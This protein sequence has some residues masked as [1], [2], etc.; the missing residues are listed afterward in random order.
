[1]RKYLCAAMPLALAL[2][3]VSC[4]TDELNENVV[5]TPEQSALPIHN[6]NYTSDE[7]Q[8][9]DAINAHRQSIGQ[10]PLDIIN[11]VSVK[12]EEHNEYMIA[13][14]VVNHDNFNQRSQE[15]I[16]VLGAN[17][18]SENIAYNYS[19]GNGAVA[20]WLKS[21][22]HRDNIEGDFT[23]FGFSVRVN[24]E[25]GKKYYTSIFIKK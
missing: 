21:P 19:T 20:A 17:K 16:S 1:M 15:I 25:T 22:D 3:L 7:M 4:S 6:Y 14:N 5:A 8:L 10:P 24:P 23:N 2:L 12:S 13:N 11:F 9:A 18:V